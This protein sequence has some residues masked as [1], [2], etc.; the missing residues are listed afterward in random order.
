M[1]L[2]NARNGCS[3]L[4]ARS[5]NI[6]VQNASKKT[7]TVAVTETGATGIV[8]IALYSLSDFEVVGVILLESDYQNHEDPGPIT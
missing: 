6:A 4:S 3:V 5:P 1:R 2:T 8:Q 7:G